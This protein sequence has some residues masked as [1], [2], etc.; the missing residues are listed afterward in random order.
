MDNNQLEILLESYNHRLEEARVLNLQS[1]V[2]NYKCYEELQTRKAKSKLKAL[3][4]VK[5]VVM[6]V[7]VL[8]VLFVGYLVYHSLE[9]TKIFFVISASAIMIFTSWAVFV[10]GQ[11]LVLLRKINNTDSVV[12]NQALIAR[13]QFSTINIT[14][15]LFLQMPFYCTFWWSIQMIEDAPAAF[16]FIS[17][18][19]AVIF[20][21]GSLWLFKNISFKNVNKKW[22][23]ILFN[24]PE[25]NVLI[26]ANDMLNEIEEFKV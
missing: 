24:S 6:L 8:W 10:Y 16:W 2:L 3:I 13:L 1:W 25:W 22:F 7:G 19:V 9:I 17:F 20:L 18:P 4:L 12:K 15:I 5:L 21:L 14:R 11:H 23:K 26:K